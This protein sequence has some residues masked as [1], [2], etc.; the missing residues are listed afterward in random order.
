M[1]PRA[2][3]TKTRFL[4]PSPDPNA[5]IATYAS[6]WTG[7]VKWRL[8]DNI[9]RRVFFEIAA[10]HP[11]DMLVLYAYKKPLAILSVTLDSIFAD[12]IVSAA[13]IVLGGA[14]V[15]CILLFQRSVEAAGLGSIVLLAV[16]P[17]PFA[18]LPNVWAYAIL[19]TMSD[20]ILILLMS[21]QMLVGVAGVLVV[22]QIG[23]WRRDRMSEPAAR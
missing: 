12:G 21:L 16:A 20:F 19:W 10:Q 4:Q 11:V 9:T 6:P 17:L 5:I 2:I 15:T 14:L 8:H 23:R 3:S 7:T 13:L 18:A 1:R 22:R